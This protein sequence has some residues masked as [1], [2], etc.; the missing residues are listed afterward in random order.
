MW[1][2]AHHRM[3]HEKDREEYFKSYPPSEPR[4]EV[5]DRNQPYSV[6]ILM[7]NGLSFSRATTRQLAVE[8]LQ[9][10]IIKCLPLQ[11]TQVR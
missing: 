11:I 10:L 2:C 1:R 4:E 3:T 5:D 8:E 6:E 7:N 9:Y